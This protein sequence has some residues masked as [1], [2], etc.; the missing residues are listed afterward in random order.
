MGLWWF[1]GWLVVEVFGQFSCWALVQK[2]E[3][4]FLKLSYFLSLAAMR[5]VSFDSGLVIIYS[6]V[7]AVSNQEI[8]WLYM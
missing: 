3:L 6:F 4:Y 5:S 7:F 2:N 8:L 1:M